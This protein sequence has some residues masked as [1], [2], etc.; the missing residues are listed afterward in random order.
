M[1]AG[2]GWL[3]LPSPALTMALCMLYLALQLGQWPRQYYVLL[4]FLAAYGVGMIAVYL[5]T[6]PTTLFEAMGVVPDVTSSLPLR[7]QMNK[8]KGNIP[9]E[10]LRAVKALVDDDLRRR[11]IVHGPGAEMDFTELI[12]WNVE[13]LL[14][15]C[16][17]ASNQRGGGAMTLVLGLVLLFIS[18][19]VE[20]AEKHSPVP[21]L[22]INALPLLCTF[23]LTH[24]ARL[25]FVSLFSLTLFQNS[26]IVDRSSDVPDA[27][28]RIIQENDRLLLAVDADD[29][30]KDD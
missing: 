8:H 5:F 9:D 26:S 11:Y 23:E 24:L 1:L 20:L 27:L 13:C 29:K 14:L 30:N 18:T 28:D 16:S 7:M 21:A 22:K 12:T 17:L 10:L 15:L 2:A 6:K 19:G 25:L 4:A 3:L